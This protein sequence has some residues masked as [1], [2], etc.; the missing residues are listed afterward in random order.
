LHELSIATEILDAVQKEA[1]RRNAR[2]ATVGL[3]IGDLSGV[4]QD[5][6]RFCF[7]VLVQGTDLDPLALTIERTAGAELDLAWLEVEEP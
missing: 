4:E 6:L 2:V 5:S 7:E 3:R 1:Q